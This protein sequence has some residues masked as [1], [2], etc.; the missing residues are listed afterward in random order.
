MFLTPLINLSS[1]RR[2]QSRRTERSPAR[3]VRPK[4]YLYYRWLVSRRCRL[5]SICGRPTTRPADFAA[6]L[7]V[8]SY[9]RLMSIEG[10]FIPAA[11]FS[12]ESV[13]SQI[14]S[15]GYQLIGGS[16]KLASVYEVI[17]IAERAKKDVHLSFR[18]E[19]VFLCV[20][21]RMIIQ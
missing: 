8:N 13:K 4:R 5:A 6:H 10:I 9:G 18:C 11:T 14:E 17:A 3:R 16:W 15:I 20:K 1:R 2:P 7:A 12:F 19:S 21:S